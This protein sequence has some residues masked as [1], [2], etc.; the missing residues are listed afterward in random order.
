MLQRLLSTTAWSGISNDVASLILRLSSGL[1]MATH[2]WSKF[3]NFAK[4]AADFP[5]PLHVGSAMSLGLTVF[6]ELFCAVAV[7]LG[8]GTRFAL[9]PLIIV[10]LV[11]SFVFH[12]ADPLGDKEHGLLYL[13]PYIAIFLMGAGRYSL[14][15]MLFKK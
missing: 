3:Q 13:F 6:A 2:G 15:A 8:L 10:C 11:I 12:A 1:L 4:D 14:D 9:I 5:D 7:A